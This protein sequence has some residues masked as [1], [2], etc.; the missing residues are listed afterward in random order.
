MIR[1]DLEALLSTR[2]EKK[3]GIRFKSSAFGGRSK[4]TNF[5]AQI[6][7][8]SWLNYDI[9]AKANPVFIKKLVMSA[10]DIMITFCAR[11]KTENVIIVDDA[12]PGRQVQT[13]LWCVERDW[14]ETSDKFSESFPRVNT[15]AI[16]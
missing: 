14:R 7:P 16:F 11:V 1:N 13:D 9:D 5:F 10:I 2:S 15:K 3:P 8:D 4:H 12:I 6:S